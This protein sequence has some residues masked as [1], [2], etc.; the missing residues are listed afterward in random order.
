MKRSRLA[1]PA[2]LAAA[3][4]LSA[5]GRSQDASDEALSGLDG[6]A[7]Q[8][9]SEIRKEL[10][11][12]NMSLG[13]G[14]K[15]LPSAEISPSGDLIIDG[16]AVTL[17][18]RQRALSLDYRTRLA[19][20]AETGA[21]VGLQGA[22]LAGKAMKEAAKAA[23]SGDQAGIEQRLKAQTDQVRTSALAL[24]NQLPALYAAEQALAAAVPEFVP[25]ADMDEDDIDDCH[26]EVTKS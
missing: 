22:A 14:R 4:L 12:E 11:T 26:A 13:R 24:C 7:D 6:L 25:Y 17:D 8:V 15:D 21:R 18:A 2:L 1:F 16:K 20:V 3:L 9:G 23:L 10:A 5:C 19:D